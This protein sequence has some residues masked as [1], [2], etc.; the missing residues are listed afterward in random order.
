M[1]QQ[2]SRGNESLQ[3]VLDRLANWSES[4]VV[5]PADP[6]LGVTPKDVVWKRG[7]VRL[8]RYRPQ[9]DRVHPVPYLIVPW[10]GISRTYVLDLLPGNSMIEFLVQKGYDTYLLDWGGFA[11]EDKDFGFEEAVLKLV[12]KAI[13]VVLDTSDAEEITL[14]G[15]CVGGT[16]TSSYLG[17]NPDA[18]VRN[19]VFIVSPIDFEQGGL[20]RRW[21]HSPFYPAELIVRRF[22]GMSPAMMGAGFKMLRPTLDLQ[23]YGGLWFN[24]DKKPYIEFFKAMN[25]WANDYIAMPGQFFLQ[26][27]K[28][29][30]DKNALV[31]GEFVLGG[32][33]VD[34]RTIKQP[35]LVV[36]A[37][38]DYIVPPLCARGIIDAVA[39]KEKEYIELP[40][41]HISVFAGRQAS[42]D[43]WPRMDEW[44]SARSQ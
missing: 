29:L 8:Y 23:A 40:G 34:L 28:E 33:T 36:A 2:S 42:R 19:A 37:A 24:L 22:G 38:K 35:T 4:F 15:I 18:P 21:L 32:Q 43:L 9:A 30:Y 7:K 5:N 39:S 44:L 26:L 11:E 31:A 17:L 41:G 12:P 1:T 13:E 10:V 16:I 6:P 14:N 27:A 3:Y 25:R 20:F